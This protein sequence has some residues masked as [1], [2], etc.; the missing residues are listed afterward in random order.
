MPKYYCLTNNCRTIIDAE[1]KKS[2]VYK[3]L[4][5]MMKNDN[6][7]GFLM[8]VTEVGFEVDPSTIIP[9]IPYARNLGI[10]LPPD[11]EI[12]ER[13]CQFMDTTIENLDKRT[14]EWFLHGDEKDEF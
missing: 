7:F 13:C 4:K 2:A 9:L 11:D 8:N 6:N 3:T 1:D 5:R 14:I 12:M 10:E